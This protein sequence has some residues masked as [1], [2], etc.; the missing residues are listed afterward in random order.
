MKKSYALITG[1]SSGIGSEIATPLAKKG[2][3]IILTARRE[4]RL[5]ALSKELQD[6]HGVH[7]DYVTG[8]LASPQT[9]QEIYNFCKEKNYEVEILVNNAGYGLPKQFHETS[10]ED[11]EKN[12]RVLSTSVI[13]LSK[14]FIPDMLEKKSGKIMIISS[15]ASFAPP[16]TIQVLYGPLK[17]FM[18]RFS[19]ALNVNYKHKGISSTAV[20]PGYVVTEFHTSSGVQ[21]A[22]DKVPSFMKLNAKDVAKEAVDA[23]LSSK[24]YCIPGK[25]HFYL[26][27]HFILVRNRC[28]KSIFIYKNVRN[29]ILLPNTKWNNPPYIFR[30]MKTLFRS[31]T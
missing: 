31:V 19:D 10:M 2:F 23:T 30:M 13:A 26:I 18:N 11:E 25:N 24:S 22:M 16:S 1:A 8:D 28:I 7:V 4:E 15:V 6:N 27:I 21:D 5:I 9:P 17:T 29:H 3:N 12:I 14:I 20:C